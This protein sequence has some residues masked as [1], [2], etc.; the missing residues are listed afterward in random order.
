MSSKMVDVEDSHLPTISSTHRFD[1]TQTPGRLGVS[2]LV[3]HI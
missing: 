1:L 3:C 2:F